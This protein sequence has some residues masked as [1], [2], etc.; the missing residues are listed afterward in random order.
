MTNR[1]FL[2]W[3][4]WLAFVLI[5]WFYFVDPDV[6][7]KTG[8]PPPLGAL[9]VHAGVGLLL[10][11]VALVWTV[12]NLRHGLIGRPGPKLPPWGRRVHRGLHFALVWLVPLTVLSGAAAGLASVRQIAAFGVVPINPSGWGTLPAHNLAKEIHDMTFS[13]TVTLILLHAAFHIWRHLRL[14]DNA[15]RIMFPKALHRWL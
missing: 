11:V 12:Q 4:H 2:K 6:P 9:G 15:L 3:L 14:K 8:P 10:A 7:Q 1:S 5:V 13:L